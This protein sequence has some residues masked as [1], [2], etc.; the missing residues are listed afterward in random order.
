MITMIVIIWGV[1]A[2][3]S[4]LSEDVM[5]PY[6]SVLSEQEGE[7]KTVDCR[8]HV[9]VKEGSLCTWFK[10]FTCSTR[11]TSCGQVLFGVCHV[12]V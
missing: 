9:S 11:R 12:S 3:Y 1:V 2:I 7:I 8:V 6:E 4:V 5:A 10:T